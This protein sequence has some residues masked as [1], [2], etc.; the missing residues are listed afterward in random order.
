MLKT[1]KAKEGGPVK[2]AVVATLAKCGKA[3]QGSKL[4]SRFRR[5]RKAQGNGFAILQ[6]ARILHA[7]TFVHP[8]PGSPYRS[9]LSTAGLPPWLSCAARPRID[10]PTAQKIAAI[11]Q[12][13][14]RNTR[15][16]VST[17][18]YLS[19]WCS[20]PRRLITR[21]YRMDIRVGIF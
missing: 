10:S 13:R 16:P 18:E 9:R 7:L 3:D 11:S 14:K 21:S 1:E 8:V 15:L 5:S 20:N 19:I 17:F 4:D 12:F 2:G 6:I